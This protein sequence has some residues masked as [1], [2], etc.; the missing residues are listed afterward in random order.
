MSIKDVILLLCANLEE[1][2]NDRDG[3]NIHK[4]KLVCGMKPSGYFLPQIHPGTSKTVHLQD[5]EQEALFVELWLDERC[6][7]RQSNIPE[8][9]EVTHFVEFYLLTELLNTVFRFGV[10]AMD[11]SLLKQKV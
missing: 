8:N 2:L 9:V 7:F 10:I 4:V 1:N 6:L 3:E 5:Q 11:S